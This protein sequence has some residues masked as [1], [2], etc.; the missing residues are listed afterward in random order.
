MGLISRLVWAASNRCSFCR[1]LDDGSS[2]VTNIELNFQ[3]A[4]YRVL[5]AVGQQPFPCS[6]GMLV[7]LSRI[8]MLFE[9]FNGR[10]NNAFLFGEFCIQPVRE[11]VHQLA[12]QF[13]MRW[14]RKIG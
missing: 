11:A 13:L 4:P 6:D 14:R 9:C 7:E 3:L 10:V 12:Q 8:D 2:L 1:S 5:I